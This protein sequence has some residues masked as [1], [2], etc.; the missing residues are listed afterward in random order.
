MH[1]PEANLYEFL[2]L[3][4]RWSQARV[5]VEPNLAWSISDIPS[6]LFNSLWGAQLASDNIDITIEA[7][8]TRGR[9]REVPLLWLWCKCLYKRG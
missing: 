1:V 5:H 3:L 7:A 9:S 2:L 4:R 6:P 8:I